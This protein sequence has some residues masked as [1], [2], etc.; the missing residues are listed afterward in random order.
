MNKILTT[1]RRASLHSI[2]DRIEAASEVTE[3]GEL[4]PEACAALD[5]LNTVSLPDKIDA[6][7]VVHEQL[8]EKGNAAKCLA[9]KFETRSKRS[10]MA[11][12]RM[13]QRLMDELGRV[14]V[15]EVKGQLATLTIEQSPPC[16]A[17]KP[18]TPIEAVDPEFIVIDKR[19]NKS[20]LRKA[21]DAGRKFAYATLERG[22][23]LRFR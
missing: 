19:V 10:Y 4:T 7:Y 3:D 13:K 17:I 5:E 9:A 11:A 1:E 6:Y 8:T 15:A 18:G 20:L 23:H 12:E 22:Q 14:G 16:V 21:M 2:I